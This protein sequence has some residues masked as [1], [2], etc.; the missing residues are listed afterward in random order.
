[1]HK[2]MNE[3][4]VYRLF[5]PAHINSG[6]LGLTLGVARNFDKSFGRIFATVE[7]HIFDALA[8]V[9]GDV[10]ID[11][12]AAGVDDR[13]THPGLHG[14]EQEHGVHCFAQRVVTPE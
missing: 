3:S 2:G 9:L 5:A 13:H 6:G 14:M 7:E 11:R 4:F 1:M 8:Q 10:L 12:E